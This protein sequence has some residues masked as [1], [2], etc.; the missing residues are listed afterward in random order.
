MMI[1]SCKSSGYKN[2]V[3]GAFPRWD[4]I[5]DG[6]DFQ[7][8][9]GFSTIEG[10]VSLLIDVDASACTF[11]TYYGI[12]VLTVDRSINIT[13]SPQIAM[14]P[15]GEKKVI[16]SG[17]A[18]QLA[19]ITG[20]ITSVIVHCFGFLST[21][22]ALCKV[23][24]RVCPAA[25]LTAPANAIGRA[26]MA[27]EPGTHFGGVGAPI[28]TSIP[29]A[30]TGTS[31]LVMPIGLSAGLRRKFKAIQVHLAPTPSYPNDLIVRILILDRTSTIFRLVRVYSKVDGIHSYVYPQ[32]LI[33]DA[34]YTLAIDADNINAANA[35]N[36][37]YDLSYEDIY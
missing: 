21:E 16:T 6:G 14:V 19:F 13:D 36:V 9:T 20:T 32:E 22:A 7:D 34:G 5:F 31:V 37:E 27:N 28:V 35:Y 8:M 3:N 4:I 17:S 2:G 18:P 1:D 15:R 25:R 30:S 33:L 24:I 11:P 26:T 12:E 29:A 10:P 23:S